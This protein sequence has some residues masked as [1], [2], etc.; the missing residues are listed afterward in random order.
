MK[1]AAMTAALAISSIQTQADRIKSDELQNFPEAATPGD[2]FRQGDIYLTLLP[3]VPANAVPAKAVEQLA[4][5]TTQ[6]SRHCLDSLKGVK[7]FT[8]AGAGELD[9]PVVLI[10]EPRTITHPEHGD[11]RL[12]AGCYGV[13]YQRNLDAHERVQRVL[14]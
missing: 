14:D 9:G 6:G 4:P 12:P 7:M 2:S 8:I 13:R 10:T 3:G 5:G 11:V 1:T